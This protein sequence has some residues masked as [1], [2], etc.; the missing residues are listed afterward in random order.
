MTKQLHLVPFG[1]S[2][3][4]NVL[5]SL[6]ISESKKNEWHGCGCCRHS[7][8]G[9]TFDSVIDDLVKRGHK[10]HEYDVINGLY[11]IHVVIFTCQLSYIR[12]FIEKYDGAQDINKVT[13]T[14]N[15]CPLLMA[16]RPKGRVLSF[17]KDVVAVV[18]YFIG[19]GA[20][21]DIPDINGY[22]LLY[23]AVYSGY[24][25]VFKLLLDN[26]VVLDLDKRY[27]NRDSVKRLTINE[28]IEEEKRNKD[29]LL[30]IIAS[31]GN[32]GLL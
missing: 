18:E 11:P 8:E 24:P 4:C 31:H 9:F 28:I 27:G 15:I 17:E 5:G 6:R 19:L 10:I 32:N 3:L 13:P 25:Q 29:Q 1:R 7:D 2:L 22:D 23:Y 14:Y 26:G 30:E 16:V 20:K 12:W 21:L